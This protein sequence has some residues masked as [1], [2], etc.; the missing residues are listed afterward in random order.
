M[1]PEVITEDTQGAEVAV[2]QMF[3]E[4]ERANEKMAHDQAEIER[5]KSET[6]EILLRLKA[7]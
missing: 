7:A 6:T 4:M 3:V 2:N 1:T 5:L